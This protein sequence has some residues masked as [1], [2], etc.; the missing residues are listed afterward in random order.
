[1]ILTIGLVGPLWTIAPL[2]VTLSSHRALLVSTILM[3]L[4]RPTAIMRFLRTSP[5]A[6]GQLPVH[7]LLR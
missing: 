1:M 2:Q 6:P 7:I 4:D 5:A 3:P